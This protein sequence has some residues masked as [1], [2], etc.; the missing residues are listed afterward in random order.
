MKIETKNMNTN[1]LQ[2][3]EQN[4][5]HDDGHAGAVHGAQHLVLAAR[6]VVLCE[7]DAVGALDLVGALAVVRR[8]A[9]EGRV[10]ARLAAHVVVGARHAAAFQLLVYCWLHRCRCRPVYMY[11]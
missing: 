3:A 2:K 4:A 10:E 1:H 11:G 5:A 9:T 6:A 8:A 7:R